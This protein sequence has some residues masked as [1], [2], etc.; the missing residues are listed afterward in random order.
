MPLVVDT[1]QALLLPSGKKRGWAL[2]LSP[3]VLGE[4]LLRKDPTPTLE[5]LRAFDI[6]LGLETLDVM[7][8]LAPLSAQEI[9]AFEPFALPGQRYRENYEAILSA[10]DYP[11]P[12]HIDWARCIKRSH[13]QFGYTL[14]GLARQFRRHLRER[15]MAKVKYATFGEALEKLAS[16]PDSFLRETI[17]A[18]S[19]TNGG[20]RPTQTQPDVLSKT[21]LEN[22]YLRRFFHTLLAYIV[23]VSRVWKDQELNLD[24]SP[25]RDD[26]T[27][28]ILPL[29]ARDGDLIVSADGMLLRL[30]SL[31][32][33]DGG[34]KVCKVDEIVESAN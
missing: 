4:I 17:I 11:R 23:C 21:V 28:V 19:I 18:V 16:S 27:D 26:M 6:R 3:Y 24:P 34:V 1:N 22:Q 9:I 7:L 33:P 25:T 32:E 8:Q 10:V 20:T 2:S 12:A 15:G 29:Y 14:F 31:I 13:L 5:R 30:L